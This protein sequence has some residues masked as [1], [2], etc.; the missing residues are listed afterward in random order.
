M[1]FHQYFKYGDTLP[2]L[3]K[4]S[5][6]LLI[7]TVVSIATISKAGASDLVSGS[8]VN[9]KSISKPV[10]YKKLSAYFKQITG[11]V[12]DSAGVIPGA[13]ISVKGDSK[14][15]TVTDP[16]GKFILDVPENAVLIV[17]MVGYLS[18]EVSTVGKTSID[19]TLQ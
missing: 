18:Q 6:V 8:M 1:K 11:T 3:F 14:T 16:N 12:R 17:G 7:V 9:K 10:S 4:P 13:T 15:G 5:L 2:V 19:V